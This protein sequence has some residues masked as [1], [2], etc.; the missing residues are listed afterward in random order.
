MIHGS[1]LFLFEI[2][3][4]ID[5]ISHYN[6]SKAGLLSAVT[7]APSAE[8]RQLLTYIRQQIDI[9]AGQEPQFDDI[10]MMTLRYNGSQGVEK[11]S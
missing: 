6:I 1:I 5:M 7:G 11:A 2:F 9:F 4:E 8:P 10:T 3:I